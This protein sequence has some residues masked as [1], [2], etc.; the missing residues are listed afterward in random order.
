M[1]PGYQDNSND[2]G[3]KFSKRV[4]DI[5]FEL[6][7]KEL[8]IG[9]CQIEIEELKEIVQSMGRECITERKE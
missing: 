9:E 8:E 5:D 4:A 6:E 3:H 7:S 1:N 2:D